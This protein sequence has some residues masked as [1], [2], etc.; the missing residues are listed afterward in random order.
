ML[1]CAW[2][3]WLRKEHHTTRV[4]KS[5]WQEKYSALDL[6]HPTAH[7][8]PRHDL[9][10]DH[11]TAHVQDIS[12]Y[13][14]GRAFTISGWPSHISRSY[15]R[16]HQ[17]NTNWCPTETWQSELLIFWAHKPPR[18]FRGSCSAVNYLS[19]RRGMPLTLN[20][21]KQH[22]FGDFRNFPLH[23]KCNCCK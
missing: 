16:A 18:T 22:M 15:I 5:E 8:T 6:Q 4:P 3:F 7:Q 11:F 14:T 2:N 10:V 19:S 17:I 9:A 23:E 13:Q 20:L 12:S 1:T 21:I